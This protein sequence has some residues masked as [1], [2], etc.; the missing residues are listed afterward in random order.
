M[1]IGGL[2]F[3]LLGM[4]LLGTFLQTRGQR[5]ELENAEL[6][7]R[8]NSAVSMQNAQLIMA[9]ARLQRR[10][11]EKAKSAFLSR[12]RVAFLKSGVRSTGTPFDVAVETAS[13]IDLDLQIDF[14]NAQVAANREV[15]RGRLDIRQAEGF[16]KQRDIKSITSLLSAGSRVFSSGLF[17]TKNVN[18]PASE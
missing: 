11:G 9:G 18:K 2:G 6:I 17:D 12:Q 16:R 1:A 5:E 8:Y 13:E 3:G 4:Q 14:F 10:R 15:Q 7:A